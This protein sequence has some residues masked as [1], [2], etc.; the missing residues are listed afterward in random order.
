MQINRRHF[1]LGIGAALHQHERLRGARA[2]RMERMLRMRTDADDGTMPMAGE[3]G[4]GGMMDGNGNM[5]DRN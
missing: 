2:D 1:L 3:R 4:S 5:M